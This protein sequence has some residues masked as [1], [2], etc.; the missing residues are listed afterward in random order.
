MLKHALL[1]LLARQPRHGYELK[2]SLEG[3]L[4]G[5]WEINFGQI[6]TTLGR[7]ERDGLVTSHIDASDKRGKKTY[8]LTVQGQ[9]EF[10]TWLSQSVDKSEVFRDEFFIKLVVRHLAGYGD[11]LAMI[12]SQR[13]A[14]LQQLREIRT[15]ATEA[16]DDSFVA[17][18]LEGA[19]LHLQADLQWLDLCDERLEQIDP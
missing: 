5:N 17:L 4:G 3:A 7:L 9:A 12:S 1:G 8:T 10:E 14:Y 13:Q 19:M 6:Y 16:G 18:L 15:L 11:A 2:N